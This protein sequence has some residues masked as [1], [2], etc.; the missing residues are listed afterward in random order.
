MKF[1]SIWLLITGFTLLAVA[2]T[3]TTVGVRDWWELVIGWS[4]SCIAVGFIGTV[5]AQWSGWVEIFSFSK[6]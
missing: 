5:T 3:Q 4:V 6:K 1:A 2:A